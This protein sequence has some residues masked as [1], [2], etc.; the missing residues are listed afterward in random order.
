MELTKKDALFIWS[1]QQQQAFDE[2]KMSFTLVL[3]LSYSDPAL[4]LRVEM[5]ALAFA[6]GVATIIKEEGIWHL[7]AY[8]LWALN[9]SKLNWSVGDKELYMIITAFVTW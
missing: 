2:L 1:E 4:P 8:M 3:V 5:N 6:I 9:G 7:A